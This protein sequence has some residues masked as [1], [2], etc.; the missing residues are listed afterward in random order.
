MREEEKRTEEETILALEVLAG[1]IA[2]EEHRSWQDG[3]TTRTK[4][5]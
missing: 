3:Y 5:D 2:E 1:E 4:A